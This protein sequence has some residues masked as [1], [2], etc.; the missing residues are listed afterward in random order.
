MVKVRL[1]SNGMEAELKS[2]SCLLDKSEMQTQMLVHT[3]TLT[4]RR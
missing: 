4:M 1:K 3:E 2:C